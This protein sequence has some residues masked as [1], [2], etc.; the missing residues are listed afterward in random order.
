MET[1]KVELTETT[2]N[3]AREWVRQNID[4]GVRCPCCDQ[5][6]KV[7][8][9]TMTSAM[10][11]ALIEMWK[12][13][14]DAGDIREWIHV[15]SSLGPRFSA[16]R[17]G[18]FAKMRYWGLVEEATGNV[19]SPTETDSPHAGYWRITDTGI[20]F[21]EGRVTVPKHIFLYD[22]ELIKLSVEP[23]GVD[24]ALKERFSY[25]DLMTR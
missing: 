17:G 12:I 4:D 7:Y 19:L 9:R 13:Y 16:A 21:V 18:D 10:A 24:E 11:R 15:P 14:K 1:E 8:R 25:T 2:L 23:L 5:F 20:A 6:A 3:S 22:G